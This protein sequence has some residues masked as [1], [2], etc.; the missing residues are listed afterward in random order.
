MIPHYFRHL[1]TDDR[2]VAP[3]VENASGL[4]TDDPK[5][6]ISIIG[7]TGDWFGGWDGLEIGS[8]DQFITEDLQ[9]GRLP[10]VIERGEPAILV[11]HWPGIYVNGEET[12]FDIFKEVVRR[13]HARYDNL[14][15]MKNSEIARYWAA[16]ERTGIER[17]GRTVTLRAPFAADAFTLQVAAPP[18]A[19]PELIVDGTPRPLSQTGSRRDLDA[20]T[21]CREREQVIVCFDLPEGPEV[22]IR[23]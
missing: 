5:C 19:R 7:C 11:C 8:A 13:L 23:L 22:Q 17:E 6:V 12:G 3:R 9:G 4:E 21:W 1:F 2:S 15:W 20:G 14:L 18:D 16:K 10:Q